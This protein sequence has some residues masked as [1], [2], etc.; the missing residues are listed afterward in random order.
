MPAQHKVNACVPASLCYNNL[1]SNGRHFAFAH[2]TEAALCAADGSGKPT[3]LKD[4]ANS[5]VTHV[6]FIKLAGGV[7][8]LVVLSGRS[9]IFFSADGARELHTLHMAEGRPAASFFRGVATVKAHHAQTNRGTCTHARAAH[10][11][12][13]CTPRMAR[14]PRT[15]RTTPTT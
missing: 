6:R 7:E 10:S 8:L 11:P 3:L 12:H 13:A 2:A 5:A 9:A 1:S 4:R 15:A 14:T